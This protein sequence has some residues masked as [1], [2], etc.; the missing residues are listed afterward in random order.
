MEDLIDIQGLS[1]IGWWPLAIGWWVLIVIAT[2]IIVTS[3]FLL[4]KRYKYKNS[5]RYIAYK[6]LNN[7]QQLLLTN[8]YKLI[9]Q[10]L[11]IEMRKIAMLSTKREECASLAGKDWLIW[12][13]KNDPRGFNWLQNGELLL[14]AQYQPSASNIDIG[15]VKKLINAAKQWVNK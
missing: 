11:S 9:I 13:H 15:T 3:I 14:S 6:K 8:D 2:I 1:Y 10:D 5:W 4:I 7:L 12:L